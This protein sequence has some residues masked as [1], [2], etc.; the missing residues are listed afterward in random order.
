MSPRSTSLASPSTPSPSLVAHADALPWFADALP[1]SRRIEALIADTHTRSVDERLA[2]ANRVASWV[3]TNHVARLEGVDLADVAARLGELAL[4]GAFV[5]ANDDARLTAVARLRR[6]QRSACR[7]LVEVITVALVEHDLGV[8]VALHRL[9]AA[10]GALEV[11][12]PVRDYGELFEA[13]A[14]AT[15]TIGAEQLAEIERLHGG[16]DA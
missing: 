7:E 13:I 11:A 15:L 2:V 10:C 6:A 16:G 3:L 9:D 1:A 12:L 5:T 8:S 4:D 14:L